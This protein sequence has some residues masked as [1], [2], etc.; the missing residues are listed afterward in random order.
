MFATIYTDAS[1]KF[2]QELNCKVSGYS[3]YTRCDKGV[4]SGTGV[5]EDIYCHDINYAEMYC[6]V[7]AIEESKEKFQS[8]KRILVVTD[9]K[10]AQLILWRGSEKRKYQ[11]IISEFRVLEKSF[12]KIMIKWTKG[13]RSDD[14]D[15]AYLNNKVDKRAGKAVDKLIDDCLESA[16]L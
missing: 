4:F 6:I 12:E 14:S 16:Y 2:S 10:N 8:L 3:Y 1:Q 5:V 15:R 9:S 7:R 13:H 11:K